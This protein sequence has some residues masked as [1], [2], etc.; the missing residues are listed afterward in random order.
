MPQISF[1]EERIT[2]L[3]DAKPWEFKETR[4]FADFFFAFEIEMELN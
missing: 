4:R 2:E 1:E 3:N